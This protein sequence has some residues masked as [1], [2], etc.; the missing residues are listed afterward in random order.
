MMQKPI[1]KIVQLKTVHDFREHLKSQNIDIPC[2]ERI[3]S[4]AENNPLA[5]PINA[6]R[7]KIGNRFCVH[8]MEGWD[9]NLDGTPSEL[10]LRR[11]E[12]FG[13]SGAKLIW[14]GE[15]YAVCEQG[16]SSPNQCGV[17]GKDFQ[18]AEKGILALYQRLISAHKKR[19]DSTD[20]LVV[21]LQLTHSGRFSF[22]HE[23]TKREP[24][25][26]VHQPVLDRRCGIALD[27]DSV[28][29]TDDQL[30]ELRDD[31]IAVAKIAQKIG[32]QFVDLKHCHGYLLYELLGARTRPGKYGGSFENRTRFARE[33]VD[34]MQSECPGLEL[35]V[36]LSAFDTIA[37]KPDPVLSQ[38]GRPGPGIPE[39]IGEPLPYMHGFGIDPNN[40]TEGNFDE[41]LRFVKMLV[42]KSVLLWNL[43]CG[44]PYYNAHLQRPTV[45]PPCDSYGS[46][47]DPLFYVAKQ[48]HAAKTF[49]Q[50]IPEAFFVGTGYTYLQDYLPHVAQGT[51][52][53]GWTD[54]VGLGRMTLAYWDLPNDVF[55]KGEIETKRLCRVLSDCTTAPRNGMPSGCFPFDPYYRALPE[56]QQLREFKSNK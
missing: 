31:F 40:P 22:P 39:E 41:P 36:R 7:L 42:E 5:E 1:T 46:P 6:G 13:E 2:E 53:N 28:V 17:V 20:D 25:I 54:F 33:L 56:Y 30:Q 11:W 26:A 38:P 45:T 9:S 43:T 51:V 4:A 18:R 37:Y 55:S 10:T 29:V 23:K 49:K 52:R 19:F 21:G 14:G 50:T 34:A 35:G 15:A 8:P 48:I 3:L 27:D 24:T 47:D 44:A 16:R 12:H 32:F